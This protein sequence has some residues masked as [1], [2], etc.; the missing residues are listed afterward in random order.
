MKLTYY[1][2]QC[3]AL[4]LFSTMAVVAQDRTVQGTVTDDAGV[5]L[6]GA[7][8]VVLETNQ[9]T[10][11]DF[12]G[13]Y[14]ITVAEGQTV[15]ISFVGYSAYEVTVSENSDFNIALQEDSLE[16]VVVTALGFKRAEKT[17][18]YAS[19]TVK[20]E[21]LTQARDINFANSLTGRAA[22]VEIRKSSSGA[23]GSTRIVLRGNKS[24]SGNSEPLIV[25]DGVPMV[26]NKGGQPGMW[27][28]ID[29]GDVLSQINP[30]DIESVN[31]LKGAN[32]SIL[33]GSQGAN[34]V[35][36]ITTKSGVEGEAKVTI[37]SWTPFDYDDVVEKGAV[38][39]FVSRISA[40]VAW[41]EAGTN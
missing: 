25:I 40:T 13:N 36:L 32:A 38:N 7:T 14:S 8:V 11:T 4:F 2:K 31:I 6:P 19:Q 27:G 26:N 34:G 17:L 12:D 20:A 18:C 30:D 21:E 16:E 15:A 1:L 37:N 24:L 28:G 9:G 3:V 41:N 22:G 35:V 23:G 10:T 39:D 33:Y 29:E 5:P